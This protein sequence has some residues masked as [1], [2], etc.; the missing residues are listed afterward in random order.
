MNRYLTAS[1]PTLMDPETDFDDSQSDDAFESHTAQ[2]IDA[3]AITTSNNTGVVTAA[4]PTVVP[5]ELLTTI[6]N[7][8]ITDE[9][10]ARFKLLVQ[11]VTAGQIP[12][13]TDIVWVQS[14]VSAAMGKG[15]YP[16]ECAQAV[17]Q[18]WWWAAGGSVV[19]LALY[20]LLRRK[21]GKK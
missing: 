12:S 1:S 13:P 8:P 19:A 15:T 9:C 18:W 16:P 20:L 11:Q 21:S 6:D 17:F 10:R 2:P 7:A 4:K 3:Q 5:A 14:M